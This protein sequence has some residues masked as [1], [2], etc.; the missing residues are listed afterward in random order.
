MSQTPRDPDNTPQP[1]AG[2]RDLIA[3]AF[4]Q[5]DATPDP[6]TFPGEALPAAGTFPGYDLIKEIHRGGQGTVFMAVQR[7]T[8]RRVALKVMHG[9]AL[10]GSAGRARFEREVQ[11]LGQL[12]HP[13]IVKIHDSGVTPGGDCF[14]VMDYISGRSLDE[15]IRGDAPAVEETIRLF[16][17]ICDGVNAAHL[18]GVIHRDLKPSN[19]RIDLAGEPIIVD[20]GLAKIAAPDVVTEGSTT[21]P[22]TITGEFVGSLP[23]AS[24]EQAQGSPEG[25]DIRSDVYSLGVILYQLLTQRFPYTVIGNMRDVLNNILRAEPQRPST[26]R[27]QINDE[28][29]TIVLRCL[30]KERGRRYQSAG[31]LARDLERYLEGEPI[32]AK[33]DSAIYVLR[34]T[35][36]RHRAA[37]GVIALCAVLLLGWGVTSLVLLSRE[38]AARV[39]AAAQ[40]DAAIAADATARRNFDT[41]RHL[42]RTVLHDLD[43][44]IVHLRGGT[45]IRQELLAQT[46]RYMERLAPQ[47]PG[48]PLIARELADA[49]D[50]YAALLAGLEYRPSLGRTDEAARHIASARAIRDD[51]L[52]RFPNEAS[53][54]ADLARSLSMQA[55]ID[56]IE[57]RFDL[58]I[59]G[60]ENARASV[61]EALYLTTDAAERAALEDLRALAYR[62]IGE[63]NQAAEQGRDNTDERL[64]SLARAEEVFQTYADHWQARLAASPES[65]EA[66][67]NV[68]VAFD[69]LT[70][71]RSR[72]VS[73]LIDVA[74]AQTDPA[75]QQTAWAN[76]ADA[77]EAARSA[78]GTAVARFSRLVE[79]HPASRE[80]RR[81]LQLAHYFAGQ[82]AMLSSRVAAESG[83]QITVEPNMREQAAASYASALA[84]AED[85]ASDTADVQAQRDVALTAIKVGQSLGDLGRFDEGLPHMQRSVQLREI[86]A[87]DDPTTRARRDAARG[88]GMLGEFYEKWAKAEPQRHEELL[89]EADRAIRRYQSRIAALVNEGLMAPDAVDVREAV[90]VLERIRQARQAGP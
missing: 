20:F 30:Q 3:A 87:A 86:L 71:V 45:R 35:L 40:R 73:V 46:Q 62:R 27:R 42:A 53:A 25:I 51:L 31:E 19:I 41:V 49:H 88:H 67:Q 12:N 38:R 15:V 64:V 6:Q 10:L 66:A 80:Y 29:E 52:A 13:N 24:P 2:D 74:K 90:N 84:I 39:E 70:S 1:K 22:M 58:A 50:L 28:V 18:K 89:A 79:R 85:L 81:D 23:W 43:G 17:K 60:Y 54:H 34:K 72:R 68:G 33:R 47:A 44:Q 21:G 14:Y 4:D 9:G 11:V 48:D 61:D 82:A 5:L 36:A 75:Q 59:A 77:A 7:A 83:G 55:A 76:A 69:L 56:H 26:V 8:K 32:E 63:A 57:G 65:A 78:V 37:A 16:L